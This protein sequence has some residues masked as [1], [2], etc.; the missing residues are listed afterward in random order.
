[1]STTIIAAGGIVMNPKQEIL[2]IF[3]RGFWDLPKGKL[4]PGETIPQC[5]LREV[6]EETGINDI[7]LN[8]LITITYHE[9]FDKYLN[10]QVTKETHWYKM[11][12][13]DLQNGIPQTEEDIEKMEWFPIDVLEIPMQ[14]TYE[15][16][17]LVIAAYLK[18]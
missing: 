16:I 10:T 11:S 15:N 17:K 2:W 9:Y 13:Q 3:R 5:A 4:D 12:I 14:H 18:S 1:M 8:E 7:Q 6:E